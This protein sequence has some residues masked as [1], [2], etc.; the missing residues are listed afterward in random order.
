M[1]ADDRAGLKP[2]GHN[3]ASGN[4][5]SGNPASDGPPAGPLAAGVPPSVHR[6]LARRNRAATGIVAVVTVVAGLCLLC[7][8]VL[9]VAAFILLG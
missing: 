9:V 1:S 6:G 8:L 4:P 7:G 3:E 2:R 5:A